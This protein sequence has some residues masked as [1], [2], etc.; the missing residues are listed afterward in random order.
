M[1]RGNFFI[2]SSA[3]TFCL[4]VTKRCRLSWLTHS[5]LV[6]EPECRGKGAVA[7]V[8]AN[9]YSC[10]QCK[11]SPNKL[12]RTKSILTTMYMYP[13]LRLVFCALEC[14]GSVPGATLPSRTICNRVSFHGG[15]HIYVNLLLY[16]RFRFFPINRYSQK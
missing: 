12:W 14:H 8:L 16:L 2:V 15:I 3:N 11:W 13:L 10:A 6:Y 7:G 9:E 1:G 4:W 5:A